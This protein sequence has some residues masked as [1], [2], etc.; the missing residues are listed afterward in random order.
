[1]RALNGL[2]R[3]TSAALASFSINVN[4]LLGVQGLQAHHDIASMIKRIIGLFP[5]NRLHVAVGDLDV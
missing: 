5:F 2:G 3:Q 4:G 1:M